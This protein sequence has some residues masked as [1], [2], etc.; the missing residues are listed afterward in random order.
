[1]R[2]RWFTF[3]QLTGLVQSIDYLGPGDKRQ[4]KMWTKFMQ[5]YFLNEG[6]GI[7]EMM[8][9]LCVVFDSILGKESELQPTNLQMY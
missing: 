6:R 5:F 8:P 9:K 4:L 1:M 2:S 7:W 3:I